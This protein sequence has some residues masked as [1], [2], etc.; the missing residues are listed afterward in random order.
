[1][2]I[3]S[4]V[5]SGIATAISFGWWVTFFFGGFTMVL[6]QLLWCCRINKMGFILFALIALVEAGLSFYAAV[7]MRRRITPDFCW[8]IFTIDLVCNDMRTFYSILH[9]I[10]GGMWL[11]SAC[12]NLAFVAS[13]RL[14]KYE[15]DESANDE[16]AVDVEEDA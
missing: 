5:L 6:H 2:V 14:A 4:V 3:A 1:M 9:Y 12:L 8:P 15:E 7:E 10:S 13:G 11:I 16:P